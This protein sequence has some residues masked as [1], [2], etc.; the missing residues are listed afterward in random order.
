MFGEVICKIIRTFFPVLKELFLGNSVLYPV[1]AHVNSFGLA[2]FDGAV[3]E[4]D[5]SGIVCDDMC[6]Q[7][8]VPPS[9]R[10]FFESGLHQPY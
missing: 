2:L 3:D 1:K 4:D 6:R 10:E 7:L 5:C 9:P 8:W